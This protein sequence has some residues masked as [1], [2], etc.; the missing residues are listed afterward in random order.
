MSVTALQIY[1]LS[2]NNRYLYRDEGSISVT[3]HIFDRRFHGQQQR[4]AL[5]LSNISAVVAFSGVATDNNPSLS[6]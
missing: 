5:V 3:Q 1:V 2:M 6:R 4:G